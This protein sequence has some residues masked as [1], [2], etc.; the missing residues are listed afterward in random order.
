M[1]RCCPVQYSRG[2]VNIQAEEPYRAS[3]K[4]TKIREEVPTFFM[5]DAIPETDLERW[6]ARLRSHDVTVR[7]DAAH[8]LGKLADER[9]VPALAQ[10][11]EDA[12]EYVRKSVV[13]ALRRIG[14][15]AA[16]EALRV[17]LGDRSE[18]VV[19]Q[20]V[21]GLRDMR[22]KGAVEP[23]IRVLARRE[24]SLQLA[25]TDALVRIGG[26][27]VGPLMEAFKD[28]NLR[29][30]IG[31]QVWKILVDM[32]SR[33]IDPLLEMMTDENQ[34]VRLTSISVLGRIGDK[35]VV[36]PMVNLFLD[37]PRM[38]EA[39]VTTLARLEERGVLEHPAGVDRE[40]TLPRDVLDALTAR[41]RPEVVKSLQ[42]ALENPSPKVRRFAM[43]ALF[44]LLG[45]GA[46]DHLV[47]ALGDEDV[48]V[49][50]LAIKIMA[51]LRDKRVVD[52]L[53]QL[54]LHD[55]EQLEE[56]AWNTL[57]V[58]TGLREYEELRARVAKER[59]GDRPQVRK[60]SRGKDVSPD[61]WREQD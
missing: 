12:D 47:K 57:K 8:Q 6:V 53:L 56:A 17:A 21:N 50:R 38:Q 9:A 7:S 4:S 58:L 2:S 60:Y 44:T 54:I 19:L 31:N 30:R 37:D 48:D 42:D 34:Y 20:A 5:P 59:A 10:A 15:P 49:K 45:E 14:G 27:A 28:R 51:R 18:Q 46:L 24:R 33:A 40:I 13:M 61:W 36:G 22:D 39:V 11:L 29:R 23:L 52:P 26:D 55:G 25:S 43:R 1:V 3:Q 32:G 41:Q 35:R 16:M